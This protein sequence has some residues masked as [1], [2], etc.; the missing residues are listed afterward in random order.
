MIELCNKKQKPPILKRERPSLSLRSLQSACGRSPYLSRRRLPKVPGGVY[1]K[2]PVK[3]AKISGYAGGEFMSGFVVGRVA[4][5]RI[6]RGRAIAW[7][8]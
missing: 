1:L 5:G 7:L 3:F 6:F 8:P 2:F 4:G